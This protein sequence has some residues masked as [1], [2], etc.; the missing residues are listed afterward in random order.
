MNI[1]I[2]QLSIPLVFQGGVSLGGIY[3]DG[4]SVVIIVI[5]QNCWYM[6][7]IKNRL[8]FRSLHYFLQF[9]PNN[10]P[11]SAPGV[12]LLVLGMSVCVCAHV[13]AQQPDDNNT[14]LIVVTPRS[15]IRGCLK[16]R[17]EEQ[18]TYEL[19]RLIKKFK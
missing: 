10:A 6:V 7:L 13:H 3:S 16:S 1:F 2:S 14:Q 4:R 11:Q 19:F 9:F 8:T 17:Y 18:K 5:V 12:D 15:G